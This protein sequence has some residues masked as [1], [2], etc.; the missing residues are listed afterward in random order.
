M[1]IIKIIIFDVGGTLVDA[2][3]PFKVISKEIENEHGIYIK[4]QLKNE[5]NKLYNGTYFYNLKEILERT[6]QQILQNNGIIKPKIMAS[7][8]YKNIFINKSYLFD[9]S[10]KILDYLKNARIQLIIVSDAD[11][12]VLIPELKKLEIFDYFDHII[13]SSDINCYKTSKNIVTKINPFLK[14]PKQEILFVG[15]TTA[16]INT[17]KNLGVKSIFIN[18]KN[19]EKNGDITITSL[20]ELKEIIEKIN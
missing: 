12:E 13:I 14:V 11:S 6:T 19:D 10:K 8:I 16:D 4:N 15:D 2:P 7:E 3:D 9:D 1:K 18:R 5:F 20:L 17:A